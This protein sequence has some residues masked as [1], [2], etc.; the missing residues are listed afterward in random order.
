M[1]LDPASSPEGVIHLS[2]YAMF[3]AAV[4][5]L[6]VRHGTAPTRHRVI[7][8]QFGLLV[9][10]MGAAERQGAK[11]FNRAFDRRLLADYGIEPAELAGQ[12]LTTRQ[13]ADSFLQLCTTLLT[14]S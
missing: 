9:K 2:Y 12:A 1:R 6:L 8:G 13:D 10:D 5:V 7:I 4:A 3:H 11:S 14:S